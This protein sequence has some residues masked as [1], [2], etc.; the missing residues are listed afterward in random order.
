MN[1]FINDNIGWVILLCVGLAVAAFVI[2]LGNRKK[3]ATVNNQ[4]PVT[5]QQNNNEPEVAE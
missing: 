3:L 4:V 2:A 1:K 5:N